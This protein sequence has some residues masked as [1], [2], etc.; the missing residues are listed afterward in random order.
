MSEEEVRR[1]VVRYWW[2]MAQDSLQSAHREMAAG[3]LHFA[4]NRAYYAL[5]YAASAALLE[6][7]REFKKHAGVR[8]AFHRELIKPGQLP[9]EY[10][11][12]YDRLFRSRQYGDYVAVATFEPGYVEEEIGKVESFLRAIHPL[13]TL[14]QEDASQ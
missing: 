8:A 1:T 10:G 11:E 13:I 12:L 9:R 2:R 3:C 4:I 6:R 5:F 14:L 7:H